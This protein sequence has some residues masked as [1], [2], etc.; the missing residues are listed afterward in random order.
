MVSFLTQIYSVRLAKLNTNNS[1]VPPQESPVAL[2]RPVE[3]TVTM[4]GV[5]EPQV[6][7]S[8]MSL[9]TGG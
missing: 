5:F 6:T 7:W 4:S 2:I 8:V 1:T 9:V 3:L